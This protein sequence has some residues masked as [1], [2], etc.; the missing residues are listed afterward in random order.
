M[1]CFPVLGRILVLGDGSVI[2][3]G[4]KLVFNFLSS[5]TWFLLRGCSFF[6]AATCLC[7]ETKRFWV[8]GCLV[9]FLPA[10][11]LFLFAVQGAVYCIIAWGNLS[12]SHIVLMVNCVPCISS[13]QCSVSVRVA[14]EVLVC[15]HDAMLQL[16]WLSARNFEELE[17][18]IE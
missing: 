7:N 14:S 9:L 13:L 18:G 3:V 12:A 16:D 1:T 4:L 10:C 2:G 5:L 15:L 11:S 17:S 6:L 8:Y